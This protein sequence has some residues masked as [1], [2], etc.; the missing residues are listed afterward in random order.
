[1]KLLSELLSLNSNRALSEGKD[2]YS[3]GD[4]VLT[5]VGGKWIPA[6]ITKPKN[7]QGNYGVRFKVGNKV[8]NYLSSL[9]QLKRPEVKEG[10]KD[11]N[12]TGDVRIGDTV[13]YKG[14][15]VVITN[16]HPNDDTATIKIPDENDPSK[17]GGDYTFANVK[18]LT[19]VDGKPVKL[20]HYLKIKNNDVVYLGDTVVYDGEDK[21]GINR[22]DKVKI[23]AHYPHSDTVQIF[24]GNEHGGGTGTNCSAKDLKK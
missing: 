18:N 19:T 16:Y 6:K 21:V 1:M 10:A 15:K 22:G 12:G 8:M 3:V 20:L 11:S 23:T 4:S 7:L 24:A 13:L 14:Q 9:E 17:R 5:Q 2:E